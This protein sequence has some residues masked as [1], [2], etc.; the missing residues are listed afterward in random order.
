MKC[1]NE[2]SPHILQGLCSPLDPGAVNLHGFVS[3]M[4]PSGRYIFTFCSVL[5]FSLC[6]RIG[7]NHLVLN[8]LKVELPYFTDLKIALCFA[9]GRHPKHLQSLFSFQVH[10]LSG[11]HSRFH[12]NIYLFIPSTISQFLYNTRG[13]KTFFSPYMKTF[14]IRNIKLNYLSCIWLN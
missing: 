5:L 7:S 13:E 11:H 4:M 9:Q 1:S 8:Y 10:H 14:K 3:S 2:L 6:D 12:N